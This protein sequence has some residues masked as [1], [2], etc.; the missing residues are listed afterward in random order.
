MLPADV[1]SLW[2]SSAVDVHVPK[3]RLTT[4]RIGVLLNLTSQSIQGA[5]YH[6]GGIYTK[7]TYN[8]LTG[9]MVCKLCVF[10]DYTSLLIRL[11]L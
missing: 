9:A 5:G 1:G 2:T 11:T 3:A 6:F 7:T 10:S 4:T 8:L